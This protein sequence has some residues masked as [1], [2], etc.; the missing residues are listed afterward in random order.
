M[1]SDL[2]LCETC[3]WPIECPPELRPATARAACP[4]EADTWERLLDGTGLVPNVTP[5][6]EIIDDEELVA[7]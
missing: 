6:T 5:L 1:A 2:K 3:P 4:R 7:S